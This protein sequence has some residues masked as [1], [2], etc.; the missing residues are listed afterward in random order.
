MDIHPPQ[1][2]SVFLGW[3]Q[4]TTNARGDELPGLLNS[5]AALFFLFTGY[6][7]LRPVRDSMAISI[8]AKQLSN[9][10]GWTFAATLM[11][12]PLFGWLASRFARRVF[13]PATYAVFILNLFGFYS[14]LSFTP[15]SLLTARLFFVWVSVV[16]LFIASL[17]WG[18][19]A[20]L[21]SREQSHRL[22]GVIAAASSTGGIVGPGLAALLVKR[23]GNAYL[24]LISAVC[25]GIAV[26]LILNLLRHFRHRAPRPAAAAPGPTS[27]PTDL[28]DK[29][30]GGNPFSGI[31]LV[32]KSPYLL[33]ISLFVFLLSTTST[34]LYLQ[35]AKL[36]AHAVA[37]AATRTQVLAT[38]DT[39]VNVLS[40][41][42]QFFVVGRLTLRV[43]IAATLVAVPVLLIAGFATLALAPTLAV[44]IGLLI[45]RRAGE[46]AICKPC[47]EM[48]FT[49]VD[50]PTKY[51]AKSFI[52]T[53]V[54]RGGDFTNA[55]LH[56]LLVAAGLSTSGLATIG[57]AV[58][59]LLALVAFLLGQVH[60]RAGRR[61]AL[62]LLPPR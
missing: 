61:A 27:E 32:G 2:P 54:Y 34:F 10:F 51:K 12:L 57:A 18:L 62:Q 26:L 52:D 17:Y 33:G 56:D 60:S 41:V 29:P 4:R 13:L 15:N 3:L 48:L 20:D 37:D 44:L 36:L 31:W 24:L 46:Y 47:R 16:N 30:L 21:F 39:T 19:M 1:A 7:I 6:A 22:F 55:K 49:S 38:V 45:V 35:Q 25:W 53:V 11:A 5:F 8:G 50:R 42:V 23:M 43:G 58:A 9:L 14:L 59:G 28:A 40:L